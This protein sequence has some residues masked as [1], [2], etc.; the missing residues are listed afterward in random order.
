MM[1]AVFVDEE[2]AKRFR[3]AYT[4]C[5][6]IM[7]CAPCGCGKTAVARKLLGG[8]K[9][10][11]RSAM[12]SGFLS[13]LEKNARAVILDDLQTLTD[14]ADQEA[15]C[16]MMR[17]GGEKKFLL[18]SRGSLPGWLMP[19]SLSAAMEVFETSDFL[20]NRSS[21]RKML[22]TNGI[23]ADEA[24]LSAID[25][26]IGGYPVAAA[27]LCRHLANGG[28]YS[29]TVLEAVK[30]D[31]FVYLDESVFRRFS[32]PTRRLLL[33]VSPFG[34]FTVDIAA[35]VSGDAQAGSLLGDLSRESSLLL[36]EKGSTYRI[37]PIF[38]EFLAWKLE[39]L[40]SRP[41]ILEFFKRAG[42][43]YELLGDLSHALE[44]YAAGG[45]SRKV[46]ELLER[47][48][49][50]H[51]GI[52]HYYD[53]EP[54]YRSLPKEEVLASPSLMCGMSMLCALTMDFEQS[55]VWYRELQQYAAGLK[56]TDAEAAEVRGKLAYLDI[57]LPQRGS[58]GLAEIINTVFRVMADRRL[59]MPA[60]S[61]TS[62]LPSIMNGGKDFCSW[63][64]KD[65][66]LY[67]SMRR[68]VET[69]LGRDGVGLADCAL[70]ESKFEKGED[71][72]GRL[73]NLVARLGEIQNKGT[74]DIEFAVVGLLAR[75]QVM[76]GEAASA[77]QAV[78][79]LRERFA[80]AG[81]ERFLPNID[82]L[83]CR[84]A[85][86]TGDAECIAEWLREKAPGDTLR[87][88]AMWRYQYMTLAMVRIADG[89]CQE[90][91]LDL[92][93]LFP[94]FETCGRRMDWIYA[95]LLSA[96]CRFRMNDESWK[97]DFC[98]ALDSCREYGFVTP[99]AQHGQAV[100]PLLTQCGWNG[101]PAFLEKLTAASRAQAVF[102][103]LFLKCAAALPEHL[104]EAEMQVLRLLCGELSNQEIAE[105]LGIKIATVKTHVSHILQKLGVNR[106]SEAKAAAQ[107]LH[108]V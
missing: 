50:L 71:I 9:T 64:G 29:L 42:L 34:S 36:F 82:A 8:A 23:P 91:L 105:T 67:L 52:G 108:L 90:A 104:T 87:L 100:L 78:E 96:V 95:K 12:E 70:C 57:S 107:R 66:L 53:V 41:E 92:A 76:R 33:S 30:H 73:L 1:P 69:I 16:A 97:K 27:I 39:Q 21:V 79:S 24:S 35:A 56:K 5:H 18:L 22:E 31:L 103:P 93:P 106:R 14:P 26:D 17:A 25:R 94:Y 6:I 7:F 77:R 75:S 40:Y 68:P 63:S 32:Q 101:D 38:R 83:L 48:A 10:V 102:Y 55:E 85:L 60:V 4:R 3:A 88:R 58:G 54:Y 74:P 80:R 62:M 65:D 49:Q 44:C 59:V 84:I 45:E 47:H 11:Y 51:P 86:H 61:V 37:Y 81:E 28:S 46:S 99:V 98:A 15:V 2:F 72:S 43:Y 20:M 13:P 89:A 19:F